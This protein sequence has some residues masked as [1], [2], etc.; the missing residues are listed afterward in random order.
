[1]R[2]PSGENEMEDFTEEEEF[3]KIFNI[4]RKRVADIRLG[5]ETPYLLITLETGQVLFVNGFH[6]EYECWQAGIS[7][8]KIRG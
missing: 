7:M 1:M 3:A 8:K 2:L 4:R 6:E 5:E